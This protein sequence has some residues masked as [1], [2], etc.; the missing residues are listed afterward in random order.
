MVINKL[1]FLLQ[2]AVLQMDDEL[3]AWLSKFAASL[4]AHLGGSYHGVHEIYRRGRGARA[5]KTAGPLTGAR[6][7]RFEEVKTNTADSGHALGETSK[8]RAR[9]GLLAFDGQASSQTLRDQDERESGGQFSIRSEREPAVKYRFS[10]SLVDAGPA[11]GLAHAPHD[12]WLTCDLGTSTSLVFIKELVMSPI[13]FEITYR[14]RVRSED[15]AAAEETGSVLRS[16]KQLGLSLSN[17]DRAP[18]RLNSLVFSNVYG[19]SEEIHAVLYAHYRQ[20]LMKN[21]LG[22]CL[23]TAALGNMN[24]LAQDLGTGVKDFFYRPIEGFVDGP[25]EGGKGLVFGTASLLGNTAKGAFGSVSRIANTVSKSLLF[26]AGDEDFIER[27]DQD[28]LDQPDNVLQGL[29]L[30]IK[31]TLTGVASGVSGIYQQP[32]KGARKSGVR[33]FMKGALKGLGGAVVKPLSGGLDLL[34]KTTE[35][36]HNMVRVGGRNKHKRA[37]EELQHEETKGQEDQGALLLIGSS[38]GLSKI[39]EFRPMYGRDQRL[40]PFEPFQAAVARNL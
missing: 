11:S 35:G 39:R 37:E 2:S 26:L 10:C 12:S 20:R 27:R 6:G 23:S 33:G 13:D 5:A 9:D 16:F 8:S 31:S 28:A 7:V 17:I 19:T 18:F 40:R 32:V 29:R 15:E 3:V 22:L 4:A 1:E 30:G 21:V 36:A 14:T 34:V 38:E 25:I 24:L